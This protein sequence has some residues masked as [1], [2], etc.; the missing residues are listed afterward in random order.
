MITDD[1]S[2][3]MRPQRFKLIRAD[4][5]QYGIPHQSQICID[6]VGS[7]RTHHKF[8]AG[9]TGPTHA[10]VL[11]QHSRG[12]KPMRRTG[13]ALQLSPGSCHIDRLHEQCASQIE[14]LIS[15]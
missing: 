5:F 7:E 13:K 1:F 8:C 3:E 12:M 9:N 10:S 2:E 6:K 4:R 15:G 11:T 14:G